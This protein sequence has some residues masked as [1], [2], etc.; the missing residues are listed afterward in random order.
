[1]AAYGILIDP[2]WCTGCHTCEVA[3]QMENDLPVGQFGIK[4]SEIGPWEISPDKWLLSY[5]PAFT[6]QCTMCLRRRKHGKVPSC[7][8]HCQA[9]CLEYGAIEELAP[10]LADHPKQLLYSMM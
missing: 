3:C 2:K 8:H 9:K 5:S 6:D 1:M 10:K 4:V 7:V